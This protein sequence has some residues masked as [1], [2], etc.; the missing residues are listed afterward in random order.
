MEIRNRTADAEQEQQDGYSACVCECECPSFQ[1]LSQTLLCFALPLQPATRRRDID[2][3]R[4]TTTYND[5][6][7]T[8][9][10]DG[11]AVRQP[12]V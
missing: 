6:S 1:N 11:H 9:G 12:L 8:T 5:I 3:A 10:G 2:R 7:D 4:T